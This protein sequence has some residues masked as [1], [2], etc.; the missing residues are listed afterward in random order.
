MPCSVFQS[1]IEDID[2]CMCSSSFS[3]RTLLKTMARRSR[4][5]PTC[6]RATPPPDDAGRLPF[7]LPALLAKHT[8][9][10]SDYNTTEPNYACI[11]FI[12]ATGRHKHITRVISAD[13]TWQINFCRANTKQ[14]S[15]FTATKKA[16][17]LTTSRFSTNSWYLLPA[18]FL[19]FNGEA[20]KSEKSEQH[21]LH[22]QQ[23]NIR[24]E[25]LPLLP[26]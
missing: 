9:Y 20:G 13:E 19:Y 16:K 25:T 5:R 3:T 23:T 1:S 10:F 21:R 22:I 8:Y 4:E 11:N 14:Q 7:R 18:S 24:A 15:A 26:E 6:V 12:Q 17:N 2:A